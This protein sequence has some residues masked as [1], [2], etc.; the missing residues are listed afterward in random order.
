[1]TGGSNAPSNGYVY[2]A[3]DVT[4]GTIASL[5]PGAYK[6]FTKQ[7]YPAITMCD[8][9]STSGSG[10]SSPG[11]PGGKPGG[12]GGPGNNQCSNPTTPIGTLL[13]QRL[14]NGNLGITY[15]QSLAIVDNTYGTNASSG[16]GSHGHTFND[17]LGS[18]GAVFDVTGNGST[19]WEAEID[20]VSQAKSTSITFPGGGSASYPSGYGTL[21]YGGDG[22]F[23]SGLQDDLVFTSTTITTDL[24]QS[25]AYYGYTT[26]SPSPSDPNWNPVDGYYVELANIPSTFSVTIPYVHN[27]P[28]K[29]QGT[30]KFFPKY[31]PNPSQNTATVTAYSGP[32]NTGTKLTGSATSTVTMQ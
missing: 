29:I 8:C 4:I 21:G 10:H 9:I 25:P 16:W 15:L 31:C 20:Y 32:N 23:I 5:A 1:V 12:P 11:G 7:L 22:K 2:H 24:N 30:I 26:S 3:A 17:L 27:S 19:V 14:S 13:T 6:T 28:S 18:D